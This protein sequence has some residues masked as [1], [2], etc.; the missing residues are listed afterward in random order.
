MTPK[1]LRIRTI[2]WV[3]CFT[4]AFIATHL[5]PSNLPSAPWISDKVEHFLGYLGLYF[6]TVWRFRRYTDS[7]TRSVRPIAIFVGL[8]AY[9]A[10]DELT[11][12]FVGRTAEWGDWFADLAGV[13]VGI[14]LGIVYDRRRPGGGG[15]R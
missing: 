5:P 6:V 7:P 2:V 4:A 13:M 14:V 8:A 9:A 11:Q 3:G 12:P 1:P 15:R 10:M